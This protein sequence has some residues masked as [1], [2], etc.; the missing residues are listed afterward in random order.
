MSTD[1][2]ADARGSMKLIVT[3]AERAIIRRAITLRLATLACADDDS[4]ARDGE[5]LADVC[6]LYLEGESARLRESR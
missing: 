1:M 2:N 6:R 3:S 4:L 5:T